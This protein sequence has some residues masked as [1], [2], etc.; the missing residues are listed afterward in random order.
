MLD[1]LAVEVG[2]NWSTGFAGIDSCRDLPGR[3]ASGLAGGFECQEPKGRRYE[4]AFQYAI[5]SIRISGAGEDF[6]AGIGEDR[7]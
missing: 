5:S 6:R 1:E 7:G 4:C 3:R 2:R